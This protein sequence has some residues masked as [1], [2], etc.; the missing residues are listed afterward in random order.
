MGGGRFSEVL[1]RYPPLPWIWMQDDDRRRTQ[2]H[3]WRVHP[4]E[5]VSRRHLCMGKEQNRHSSSRLLRVECALDGTP[6]FVSPPKTFSFQ[7]P[8]QAPI[9]SQ[10]VRQYNLWKYDLSNSDLECVGAVFLV[11]IMGCQRFI[12]PV[13]APSR[14]PTGLAL[15]RK[16]SFLQTTLD[17]NVHWV[18]H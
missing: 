5:L 14:Y 2:D 1:P 18:A 9:W 15:W 3:L 13:R 11:F 8:G 17:K 6:F 12:L 4:H 10:C 16:W 7:S